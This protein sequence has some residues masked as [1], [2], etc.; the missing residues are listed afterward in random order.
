MKRTYPTL[1]KDLIDR[2]LLESDTRDTVMEQ[3]ASFLWTEVVGPGV[4]RYTFRRY[5]DHGVLHVYITS[6]P[7]KNDLAF[8]RHKIIDEINTRLG[9]KVLQDIV[10][11]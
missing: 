5:V 8:L 9:E 2:V 1:I 10:I 11:H 4:N 6:A 7:L 3:R